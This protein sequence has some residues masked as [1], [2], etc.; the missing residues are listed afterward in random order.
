MKCFILLF[1]LFESFIVSAINIDSL[2]KIINN[3]NS[4]A[5]VKVASLIKLSEYHRKDFNKSV[6]YIKQAISLDKNI[7]RK[8]FKGKADY[9]YGMMLMTK[10]QSQPAL[11]QFFKSLK[12]FK[13]NDNINGLVECYIA[14]GEVLRSQAEYTEALKYL[15]KGINLAKNS[16][17]LELIK[18]YYDRISAVYFE[19]KDY[20]LTLIY[21]D[22][23][24]N[25][26]PELNT[27][28]FFVS[29]YDIK[30]ASFRE[31][32]KYDS[33]IFYLN[34]AA[35]FSIKG[36]EYY[37]LAGIYNNIAG[38]YFN[39]KKYSNTIEYVH[40]SLNISVKDSIL[41]YMEVSYLLL[42]RSFK[43]IGK[44][45]S[46]INYLLNYT[47]IRWKE[48]DIN[49]SKE[50][51]SVRLKYDLENVEQENEKLLLKTQIQHNKIQI[52]RAVIVI[53]LLVLLLV[54][55]IPFNINRKRRIL[56]K[57][58]ELLNKQNKEIEN[59]ANELKE[60]N[61]TKDK[62]LSIIAHDIKNPFQAL[63]GFSELINH[64]IEDKNYK[65]LKEYAE[66]IKSSIENLN[67]LLENLLKW[68][69]IQTGKI[70]IFHENINV[71]ELINSNL[72]LFNAAIN[73]KRLHIELIVKGDSFIVGDVISLS[74][75]LRNLVSN[76]IKFSN[77]DNKLIISFNEIENEV[78]LDVTD[79]GIGMSKEQQEQL[80][81][82][83]KPSSS[84]TFNEKGSGL[85]L[86]LT[87][88][89]VEKHHGSLEVVSFLGKGTSFKVHFPKITL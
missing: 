74:I 81:E 32:K 39:Q 42:Y 62:I 41:S 45:D 68:S 27:E 72:K 43:E 53:S 28:S 44:L 29:V 47:D 54:F 66:I 75:I 35:D 70:K 69:Q 5:N 88:E 57:K 6:I 63:I 51:A 23:A 87:K 46:A 36:K 49:R 55:Y 77:I 52:Q 9:I 40:K 82:L 26:H 20:K 21:C 16:T 58:N 8:E 83:D 84:G 64:D 59:Q 34:R 56:S 61:K 86:I 85:G 7:T 80:F 15:F 65:N 73:Q 1:L 24:I 11:Q 71:L 3:K 38:L 17:N 14:I 67:F 78:I 31:L 48:F 89:L 18:S 37:Y 4:S 76:A 13:E 50:I 25:F 60:L 12:I 19:L 10:G 2:Q 30:G 79:Y 33:A 22:S